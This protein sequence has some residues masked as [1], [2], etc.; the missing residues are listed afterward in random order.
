M[1]RRRQNSG[2]GKRRARRQKTPTTKPPAST[3]APQSRRRKNYDPTPSGKMPRFAGVP[4]LLRLPVVEVTDAAPAWDVLLC[5]VP[6]D[7]G[8]TFRPGARFGPRAVRDASGLARR[9][10][11]ALGIDIYEELRVADGGDIA[12]MPY[13]IEQALEII[14]ARAEELARTGVIGGFVGGDQTIS[15]GVLR[16]IHRAK[17]KPVGLIHIDSHSNSSGPALGRDIHHGSVLRNAVEAGLI[18]ADCTIQV[19]VRGPYSSAECMAFALSHG[20]DVVNIDEVKWDLHAVVSQV[21][22]V[23]SFGPVY[24]SVDVSAADP[25]YA[26][27][28]GVPLPGGMSS[29][30]LQ[31]ILR[32]LVGA[33]IVAFDVV[34]I[35]PQYDPAG[36]TAQ[37]GVCVLQEILS[38]I[39]D[40]RRSVRPAPSTR[41]EGRR[42]QRVSP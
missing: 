16:G 11:A 15:L 3:P 41:A 17:L 31:Q 4:S 14:A 19:G 28:V 2:S 37:L 33:D 8:S 29:W 25:A 5:G 39:A 35:A 9:F 1:K 12:V 22:R 10:S 13:D 40:T 6:F 7:G 18:R 38:A 23:A 42:G 30:E 21:R 26:P 20:F 34:E 27:G 32:A 24:L 36:I